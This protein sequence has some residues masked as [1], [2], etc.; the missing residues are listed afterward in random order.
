MRTTVSALAPVTV[1]LVTGLLVTGLLVTGSSHAQEARDSHARV[2][3]RAEVQERSLGDLEGA[4]TTYLEA[5]RS[6]PNRGRE[7]LAELRAAECLARAG[8]D[9]R[10]REIVARW[11]GDTAP[12]LSD[13]LRE[14]ALSVLARV[15]REAPE[16]PRVDP[17]PEGVDPRRVA[18]LEDERDQLRLR[19]QSAVTRA[20]GAEANLEDL[21]NDVR[22]RD[23]EI[24]RLRAELPP[25][26][27]TTAQ[28]ILDQRRLEL[29]RQAREARNLSHAYT[30]YARL[31]H[32]DGRFE[33]ATTTL[34]DALAKNPENHEA[35]ALLARVSVPLGD[36]EHL[37]ARIKDV[38][39]LAREVRRARLTRETEYLIQQGRRRQEWGDMESSVAP[40]ERA[41]ALI[42]SGE[43]ELR[44]SARVR[45]DVERMLRAAEAAGATRRPMEPAARAD[46]DA[47]WI[48]ALRA[49]LETAGEE[50]AAGLALHFHDLRDVLPSSRRALPPVPVSDPPA[51]WTLSTRNVGAA[52][53]ALAWLRGGE[54]AGLS[55]P[56]ATL[57]R[58][59]TTIVAVADD[60]LHRRVA[61]RLA[62]T[63][64]AAVPSAEV[65]VAVIS[66]A[67]QGWAARL[68]ARGLELRRSH[69]GARY[70]VV[71][72]IDAAALLADRPDGIVRGR[73]AFRA[74]HLRPF[75]LATGS[76]GRSIA[77]D[78]L[79]VAAGDPGAGVRV[80]TTWLPAER[81]GVAALESEAVVGAPFGG[82]GALV[83]FGL[84]D[85]EDPARE[86]AVIVRVGH[87]PGAAPLPA[88]DPTRP[89]LPE[90]GP[91]LRAAEHILPRH[92]TRLR[93][94]DPGGMTVPGSPVPSRAEA[95]RAR[96]GRAA[97]AAT[98]LEVHDERVLV[99][100]P[101]ETHDGVR[102][103]LDRLA[104]VRGVQRFQV[105]AHAVS[106]DAER[107]LMNEL[108]ALS[109]DATRSFAWTVTRDRSSLASVR[110]LLAGASDAPPLVDVV[111]GAPPTVRA[112]AAHV[113]R[114][115][116][117]RDLD[118]EPGEETSWG[119]AETGWVDQGFLLVLRP[120][121]VTER[122]RAVLDVNLR[123]AWVSTPGER[124]R[125]TP[126]GEV[127]TYAPR[128]DGVAGDLA[129]E[130]GDDD[131]LVLAGLPN[132][133]DR[134]GKQSRLVLL[135]APAK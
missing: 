65:E 86:L 135:I 105:A 18:L 129:V 113:V 40:L 58:V 96:L 13:E 94:I 37:Y 27:P 50:K 102:A 28:E 51:G 35:K 116:F 81:L 74:P 66:E 93:E 133:F 91:R 54:T 6:A 128:V 106:K 99:V 52:P 130:L 79:P 76:A 22:E 90:T 55:A 98:S 20:A 61:G 109:A 26:E 95:L 3:R 16:P 44:G 100:G 112:T 73:G 134:G 19:L 121:G 69:D 38:L 24:D 120:F 7:A 83:V 10:A 89:T 31:L 47:R 32:Q 5:A 48:P 70:A 59:G 101:P 97:T 71:S 110:M 118:T 43:V 68:A 92:L 87:A 8:D 77:V 125:E 85:P 49:L 4:A 103:F 123:L 39:A 84:A 132:P 29:E 9:Q 14:F 33:D 11:T 64:I 124:R 42:A 36:R 67:G 25:P 115:P 131:V 82:G 57:D 34:L 127:R 63:A 114:T 78:I 21:A 15:A 75:R 122:Q 107:A 30:Q 23:R 104:A 60:G 53:L 72:P 119:R 108:P 2:F 80:R 45:D 41:L 17:V 56:G 62:A 88:A 126:L 111:E 12:E 117:R 46:S 1:F